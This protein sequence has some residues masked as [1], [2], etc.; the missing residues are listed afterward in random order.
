M[1]ESACRKSRVDV[2]NAA[3]SES[4]E[5]SEENPL[6]RFD[7]GM[8]DMAPTSPSQASVDAE[9]NQHMPHLLCMLEQLP[10]ANNDL[11]LTMYGRSIAGKP[12]RLR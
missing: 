2:E 11:P 4:P 3:P 8:P 1:V 5:A 6:H 7:M 9:N 10:M 12:H